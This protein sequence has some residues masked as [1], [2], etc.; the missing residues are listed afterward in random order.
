MK[1]FSLLLALLLL[2]APALAESLS[3]EDR[4]SVCVIPESVVLLQVQTPEGS[5]CL[6]RDR[7]GARRLE[8]WSAA[9]G[10]PVTSTALPEGAMLGTDPDGNA[11]LFFPHPAG[12]DLAI[13]LRRS[14]DGSWH[15]GE[16]TD[17]HATWMYLDGLLLTADGQA[18]SVQ[19]GVETD[20]TGVDW[21]ALPGSYEAALELLDPAGAD[22][23]VL[24]GVAAF[25]AEHLPGYALVDGR[26]FP[27]TAMLLVQDAEG[28]T[29]FV[30]GLRRDG[31]W[32]L[33]IS[34][35]LP[36]GSEILFSTWEPESSVSLRWT[37]TIHGLG[38]SQQAAVTA[39][40]T[41]RPDGRWLVTMVQGWNYGGHVVFRD[42][43]VRDD[44]RCVHGELLISTDIAQVQW[45]ALPTLVEDA[46]DMMD[47]ANRAILAEPADLLDAPGGAV[48]AQY[49]PGSFML[50]LGHENGWVQVAPGGSAISGWM[51]GAALLIGS[52]QI[53]AERLAP[54]DC[55][56]INRYGNALDVYL[57]PSDA[58]DNPLLVRLTGRDAYPV[59][60]MALWGDGAWTQIYS[61]GIPGGV[62]FVR[63]EQL[64]AEPEHG[65][66]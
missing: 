15:I 56:I 59:Y 29:F 44:V 46:A 11:R 12:H 34:T 7:D 50:I 13:T 5:V 36:A 38:A 62:G 21:L 33:T 40:V 48:L 37:H 17:G 52:R 10:L 43:F 23:S 63:T 6:I 16:M 19:P 14:G 4:Y 39:T 66:G 9:G 27:D 54:D 45:L 28:L 26:L 64:N 8:F 49:N 42:G 35:A 24:S 31:A 51:P 3:V 32:Q 58:A 22:N 25:A 65:L 41:P 55:P 47:T 60:A 2:A 57:L 18:H 53:E 61:Q 1:L 30:G 20:V